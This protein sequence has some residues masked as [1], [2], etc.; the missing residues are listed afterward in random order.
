VLK[1][2]MDK[3]RQRGH[4]KLSLETGSAELFAPARALYAAHGF[5]ECPPFAKY[6]RDPLSIFMTRPL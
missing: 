1:E 6:T 3:A 2:L 4:T 5:A